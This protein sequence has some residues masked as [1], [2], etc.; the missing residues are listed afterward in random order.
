VIVSSRLDG[1]H[2]ELEEHRKLGMAVA[3]KVK[4]I[5]ETKMIGD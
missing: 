4:Q 1:I 2:I 3:D 5:L